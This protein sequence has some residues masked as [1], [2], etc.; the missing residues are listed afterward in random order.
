LAEGKL[1][2]TWLATDLAFADRAHLTPV[3]RTVTGQR[4]VTLRRLLV[5]A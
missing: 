2:L 5:Q 3:V 4:P 1:S